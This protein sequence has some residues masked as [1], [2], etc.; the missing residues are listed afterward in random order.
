MEPTVG[1]VIMI[2]LVVLGFMHGIVWRKMMRYK[3]FKNNTR[4]LG[5]EYLTAYYIVE[6]H[7][8]AI[9]QLIIKTSAEF[10]S[11]FPEKPTRYIFPHGI[12]YEWEDDIKAILYIKNDNTELP[13][14]N[15]DNYFYDVD[16]G[17]EAIGALIMQGVDQPAQVYCFNLNE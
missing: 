3:H 13:F 10:V 15:A 6:E 14:V 16:L 2:A 5:A 9:E 12:R 7:R 1:I 17:A 8:E 11:I 4:E